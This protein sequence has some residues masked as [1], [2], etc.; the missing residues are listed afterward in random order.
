MNQEIA[1]GPQEKNNLTIGGNQML[2]FKKSEQGSNLEPAGEPQTMLPVKTFDIE[3]AIGTINKYDEQVD[4]MLSQ[5]KSLAINNEAD[6]VDATALGTLAMSVYKKI[7]VA[8]DQISNYLE[9]K[10]YVEKCDNF[11]QIRTEKLYSTRK[12]AGDTIVSIC[13]AKISQ[14]TLVQENERRK[15]EQIARE[16][17]EKLNKKLAAEAKVAGTIP[18]QAVAPIIP[19]GQTTVRTESGSSHPS[20]VWTFDVKDPELPAKLFRALIESFKKAWTSSAKVREQPDMLDA[21]KALQGIDS[22][23]PYVIILF[24]DTKIREAIKKGTRNPAINGVDIY[25]KIDT[26]FRAK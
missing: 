4:Q 1:N 9:A 19:K 12:N 26:K 13:K 24:E 14:W 3:A 8:K 6:Q 21:Q 22:I 17:T 2:I 11:V 18:V 25:E 7:I 5:A 23:F 16:E 15:A 10:E 20:H